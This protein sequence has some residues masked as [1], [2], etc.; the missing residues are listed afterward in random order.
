MTTLAQLLGPSISNAPA[1]VGYFDKV[2]AWSLGGNEKFG[3]C[4]FVSLC[5]LVDLVTAV[6]G[7][8]EI[9]PEAE[10]EH[11]Y[12]VE[13]GFNPDDPA[14][15]HGEVLA[16]VIQYWADNG[17]PGDPT[18]VPKGWCAIEPHQIHQ[19]VWDLGGVP[20]WCL[21]PAKGDEGWDFSDFALDAGIPGTGAHAILIVGSDPEG[22]TVVSWADLYRVSWA[23]WARYGQGQ[24]AVLH[25]DWKVP[26]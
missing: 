23:W 26:A 18:S 15:D 1:T 12:T 13:A 24:F 21:L 17:W 9:V 11:F 3:D 4:T 7:D 6:N 5:N 19:A 10:A 2:P 25:P 8:P 22:F 14:T 20:A 16:K